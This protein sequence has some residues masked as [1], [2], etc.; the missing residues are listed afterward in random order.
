M[1]SAKSSHFR[2][3]SKILGVFAMN[4]SSDSNQL[5]IEDFFMPFGENLLKTNRLT[6]IYRRSL[7]KAAKR[8]RIHPKRS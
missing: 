7:S 1:E 6:Q 5:T 4:I 2:Q 3:A 8:T